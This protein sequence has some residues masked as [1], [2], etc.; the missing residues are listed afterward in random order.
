MAMVL[1]ILLFSFDVVLLA[2]SLQILGTMFRAF[3][4]FC[5]QHHL[6]INQQKSKLLA[7]GD[8]AAPSVW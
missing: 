2:P 3:S 7:V 4:A 1:V 8:T 5:T 6:S